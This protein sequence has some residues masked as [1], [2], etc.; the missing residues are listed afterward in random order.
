MRVYLRGY[1]I[2]T[3]GYDANGL[4]L[5]ATQ[6]TNTIIGELNVNRTR[7][8]FK[9]IN[10]PSILG[11]DKFHNNQT[12]NI[13]LVDIRQVNENTSTGNIIDYTSRPHLRTSNVVMSISGT[14]FLNGKTENILSQFTNFNPNMELT[15]E[16][17]LL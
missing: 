14:S 1:E 12:F 7:Y 9:N 16:N 15:F 2:D 11:Y 10:L 8:V 13:K 6:N 17:F 3:I 5:K 4:Q